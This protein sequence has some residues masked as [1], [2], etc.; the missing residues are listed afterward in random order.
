MNALRCPDE[1]LST[2]AATLGGTRNNRGV[3]NE[4]GV[5]ESSHRYLAPRK[6]AVPQV[7]T[8]PNP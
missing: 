3:S 7:A 6:T 2:P 4:N 1:L 5:V 8:Q